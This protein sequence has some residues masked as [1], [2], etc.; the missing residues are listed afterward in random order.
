MCLTEPLGSGP[1]KGPV[2]VCIMVPASPAVGGFHRLQVER[3]CSRGYP[4]LSAHNRFRLYAVQTSVHSVLT[5]PLPRSRNWRK[6]IGALMIPN[7]GSTV[8]LRFA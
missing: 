2:A 3:S 5:F 1:K 6:P 8:L 7:V 4:G